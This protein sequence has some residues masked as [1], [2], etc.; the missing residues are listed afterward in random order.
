MIHVFGD[1]FSIDNSNDSWVTQLTATSYATRGA[2]EYRIWKTYQRNK[3]LI[4]PDDTILFCHTSPYRVFLKNNSTLLSRFLS[5]HS[6]CDIIINDIIAKKELK[7]INVLNTIWD[8][9]YF[10]DT[11]SLL[12][13]D[14]KNIPNSFHFTFFESE[15]VHSFYETWTTNPGTINH[16][17]I[18]GNQDVY[19]EISKWLD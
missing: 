5:S 17:T 1:S 16:L 19:K 4:K 10:Y 12:V 2:S 11:Y 15:L 13:N 3:H 8:E 6:V 18:K 7:F 14:L 9:D